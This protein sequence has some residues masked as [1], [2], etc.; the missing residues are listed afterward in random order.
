MEEQLRR[1]VGEQGGLAVPVATLGLDDDLYAVGLSSLAAIDIMLSVE[2][3]FEVEFTQGLVRR[4]TFGSIGSLL[5]AI[6]QLQSD[7][8]V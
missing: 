6:H 3:E 7:T 5:A 2:R 8:L 1:L 4:P